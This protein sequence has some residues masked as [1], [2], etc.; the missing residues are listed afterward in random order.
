MP[1]ILDQYSDPSYWAERITEDENAD[2]RTTWIERSVDV[3]NKLMQ[4]NFDSKVKGVDANYWYKTSAWIR[5]WT[6][7]TGTLGYNDMQPSVKGTEVDDINVA[8]LYQQLI[9]WEY[10]RP[11]G[12]HRKIGKK[13]LIKGLSDLITY[14]IGDMHVYFDHLVRDK[15]N[16][17]GSIITERADPAGLILDA[18]A[19][20]F[21]ELGYIARR[22]RK[23]EVEAQALFPSFKGVMP[24]CS[25]DKTVMIYECEF[26]V[27]KP[28]KVKYN[29]PEI[30]SLSQD[31]RPYWKKEQKGEFIQAFPEQQNKEAEKLWNSLN[32]SYSVTPTV[33]R[34]VFFSNGEK[35]KNNVSA[36]VEEPV[37][38]G[39]TFTHKL[40]P[41]IEQPNS[42]YPVG[43]PYFV[44]DIL[45]LEIILKT[46]YVR[47]LMR[48]NNSGG[49]INIDRIHGENLSVKLQEIRNVTENMGYYAPTRGEM[50]DVV[51]Q[52]EVHPPTPAFI[53]MA[54]LTSKESDEF[55][56][57]QREMRGEAPF[58]QAS[59]EIT[60]VLQAAG[61]VPLSH[62]ADN[63][64]DLGADVFRGIAHCAYQYM[65]DEKK[66]SIVDTEG[67]I[68]ELVVKR[69]NITKTN[70]MDLD[71]TVDVDHNTDQQ[72]AN[73]AQKGMLLFDRGVMGP[74]ELLKRM[75]ERQPEKILSEVESYRT[76]QTIVNLMKQDKDFAQQVNMALKAKALEMES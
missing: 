5:K 46:L 63:Y 18:T 67:N 68:D 12:Y 13:Q 51:K 50:K 66:I 3:G 47:M 25:D 21:D 1:D 48:V 64:D 40:R 14:G 8:D 10:S 69:E 9:K 11:R 74:K 70:P 44:D 71:I 43:V 6:Y 39:P 35:G 60:K 34:I 65:P 45:T 32:Y 41:L 75:G 49:F 72:K 30:A 52:L 27:N 31:Y 24:L 55:F 4:N 58:A 7:L 62:M 53:E 38:V 56:A 28:I 26:K 19:P 29:K 20:S 37:Y 57:T 42:P 2:V 33:Y 61:H 15:E 76:G 16:W 54:L 17:T 23:S 73:E 22:F 36:M 59:G